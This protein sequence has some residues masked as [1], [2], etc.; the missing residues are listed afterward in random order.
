M[1]CDSGA[2]VYKIERPKTGDDTRAMGPFIDDQ[3]ADVNASS[4]FM[5]YNR[6]KK[7][8]AIDFSQPKGAELVRKLAQQCDVVIENF[9][10]SEERR[11]GK[12]R[13]GKE[14]RREREHKGR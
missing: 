12:E 9:K 13:R 1:L 2:T 11:V 14:R 6:G 4:V 5:A 7:S 8:L 10:R 3:S